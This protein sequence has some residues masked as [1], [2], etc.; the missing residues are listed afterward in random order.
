MTQF[1]R[2]QAF[3]LRRT[4][5]GEADRIVSLLTPAGLVT[6]LARGARKQGNKLAGG[7][8]LFCLVDIVVTAKP[9]K[10]GRLTSARLI[11]YYSHIIEDYD[12]LEFAYQLLK[13]LNRFSQGLS[14][15]AW[16]E[17]AQQVFEQLNKTTDLNLI[18]AW[19]YLHAADLLGESFNLVSD[20]NSQKLLA[21]SSY[22]YDWQQKALR[23][24]IQGDLTVDHLKLMRLLSSNSLQVVTKVRGAV[25][26]TETICRAALSH[27]GLKNQN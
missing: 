13:L 14:D 2:Y 8:E 6:V 24:S 19:F 7:L 18:K 27:L 11:K 9:G 22:V 1:Q 23:A 26:L 17:L 15:G 21:T 20:T 4:N 25:A 12:R 3:V 5:Y 16:F 10:M